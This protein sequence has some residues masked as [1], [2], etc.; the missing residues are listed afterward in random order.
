MSPQNYHTSLGKYQVQVDAALNDLRAQKI[1]PR[2]WKHDHTVWKSDPAEITNRL[3]WLHSPEV[4]PQNLPEIFA[5]VET[6]RAAGFTHALLL[7]M[8]GS[9]L[10]PEVFRRTFG[11]KP[12]YLDLAVLDST[13]PGAVLQY[14]RQLN[15]KKT[16]FIVSTKSG[17]T[18]ET[19]SFFKYFY[20]QV[21]QATGRENAGNH[22]VAITDPG[23]V[24]LVSHNMTAIEGLCRQ[25]VW[26]HNGGLV[27]TGPTQDV[28]GA[29][30]KSAYGQENLE[31][32]RENV[33][34]DG[35]VD[36]VSFEAVII[37]AGGPS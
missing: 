9:S 31:I 17:G 21:L 6:L 30:L 12:G 2:L 7:G 34:S 33:V 32:R 11:V 28:V 18:V 27:R 37:G 26:L 8:G 16:V 5:C 1:L 14:A 35:T 4:M 15:L 3:G 13:H 29:Y 36:L 20:N 10:A 24:L 25:T 22:F 23:T 19:F